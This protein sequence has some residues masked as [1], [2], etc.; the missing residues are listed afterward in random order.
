V[1]DCAQTLSIFF[2]AHK[3]C[4]APLARLILARAAG[5]VLNTWG[6]GDHWRRAGASSIPESGVMA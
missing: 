1:N 5:S 4:S 3:M 6:I 2:R